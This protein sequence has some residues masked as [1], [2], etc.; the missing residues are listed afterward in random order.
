MAINVQRMALSRTAEEIYIIK[1]DGRRERFDPNK[2]AMSLIKIGVP[3]KISARITDSISAQVHDG[4]TTKELRSIVLNALLQYDEKFALKYKHSHELLVRTSRG[5]LEP[6]DEEKITTSLIKECNLDRETAE[7]ISKKVKA[8]LRKLNVQYLTAPLIREVVTVALLEE[9]LEDARNRYT[10]LGMPVY[11]VTQLIERGSRENANL[12]HNPETVHKFAGDQILREYLLVSVL[13]KHI[14]DAHMRGEIHLHDVE[15]YAIRPNC[16]QHDLRWFMLHGLKVDGTGDHTSVARA[17][18][19]ASVAALHAAKILAASQT[20]MAGGQAFDFFNVFMAPFLKGLSYREVKQIAQMFVYEM[21]QQYVA[22]GGQVVFSNVGME[23]DVP[24]F[25]MDEP[26]VGPEGKIVGKYGDFRDEAQ[27]FLHAYLDVLLEGD[28]VGK[29]HLFPNTIVKVRKDS[30]TDEDQRE[31]LFKVHQLFAKYGTP[32]IANLIPKWQTENANYMGCRTRLDSAWGEY[33]GMEKPWEATIRTGNIHYH[34][35]NLPRIAYE[36]NG[37]DS[38]VFEILDERL[39]LVEESLKIKHEIIERRLHRDRVLPFL[40]QSTRDGE[41]YYRFENVTHTVGYVGMN[42]FL[43][44]HTGYELHEDDEAYRFALDVAEYIREW[45]K[46]KQSETGWRWSFT[47]TP[48]ESTAGRFARLDLRDF[49]NAIVNGDPENPETVYYTNSSHLRVSAD[50]P[51]YRRIQLEAKFHP[52]TNGG[53]IAHIFLGEAY[54]EPEALMKLTEKICKKT[55]VGLFDYTRDLTTCKNCGRVTGGLH[56][57][58]PN[59]GASGEAIEYYSRITG[60]YQ[61]IGSGSDK[62]G[63][64]N[65]AKISELRDRKRYTV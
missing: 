58:C 65:S 59:C 38:R 40:S 21:N 2:I 55:E 25:L 50:V 43:K 16:L 3:Y 49:P 9:G 31:L 34:T 22:R 35:L 44:Y 29:P 14:A 24:D 33:T 32:Y 15:Y 37:D 52:L 56:E 13:P 30:F 1:S 39:Q 53:H 51:L 27:R 62:T 26:A 61:R 46:E 60:Y 41:M 57:R 6:F 23:L 63:G 45:T 20:N 11:D 12:H 4:M 64:W 8:Q 17:P 18:K 19:H 28:A 5:T 7:K 36:A 47:Q 42:E 10:R 54:P 48:A